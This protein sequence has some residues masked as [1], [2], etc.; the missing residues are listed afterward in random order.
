MRG[1][2]RDGNGDRL[3]VGFDDLIGDHRPRE[4]LDVRGRAERHPHPALGLVIEV[5]QRLGQSL[6]IGRGH[7]HAVDAVAHDVAVAGDVGG[8]DRRSCGERLGEHH[9]EALAPQ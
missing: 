3:S 8:D 7:E 9:S 6:R 2:R 1:P 5:A 4:A